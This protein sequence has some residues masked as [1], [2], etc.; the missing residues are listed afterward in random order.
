MEKG[1]PNAFIKTALHHSHLHIQRQTVQ[2]SMCGLQICFVPAAE[3]L[4]N[5]E[6]RKAN[7]SRTTTLGH[8][9]LLPLTYSVLCCSLQHIPSLN[10]A[11]CSHCPPPSVSAG[12]RVCVCESK[13]VCVSEKKRRAEALPVCVSMCVFAS[14]DAH[15]FPCIRGV[16][17]G[18]S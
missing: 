6:K 10:A 18:R 5:S 14:G 9:Q 8:N 11:L 16:L 3:G 1:S 17:S 7:S 15:V 13:C 2:G 4:F 12:A